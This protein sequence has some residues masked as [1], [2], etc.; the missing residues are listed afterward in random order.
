MQITLFNIEMMIK[1]VI[2]VT[3]RKEVEAIEKQKTNHYTPS[4]ISFYFQHDVFYIL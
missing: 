2:F 4:G 3:I 1:R